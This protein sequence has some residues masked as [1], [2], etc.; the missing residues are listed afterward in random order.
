MLHRIYAHAI[1]ANE[2]SN[3]AYVYIVHHESFRSNAQITI[4]FAC[5]NRPRV[6]RNDGFACVYLR[7]RAFEFA[8]VYEYGLRS[9]ACAYVCDV[10]SI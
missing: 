2:R 8:F 6:H 1:F 10:N 4:T 3:E 5:T 9:T 7:L